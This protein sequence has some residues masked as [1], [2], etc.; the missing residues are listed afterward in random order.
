M[1]DRLLPGHML[2]GRYRIIS[3]VGT[4]GFG[5]VYKAA[6]SPYGDRPVAVKEISL[7]GLKAQE[8]IEATDTFNRE[9]SLLSGLTHPNLP[10]VYDHFTD[11][12]HWYLVME[13][14]EGETLE[15][16][17][18]RH[19]EGHPGAIP[20]FSLEE[21]L[22]M[23]LQ[24]CTVLDYLHKRQPPIIFRDLKPA[25]IMRTP[26]GQLYLIDF[27]IARRFTPGQARDT[28][29]FGSPGYAAP[30]QYG[31]AQTTP[32]ADIYSLGA[33]LHH[34][35]TGNDPSETPFRFVPLQFYNQPTPAALEALIRQMLDV[36]ENKRPASITLVKR[37]L[38]RITAE[39]SRVLYARQLPV[40]GQIVSSYQSVF[41]PGAAARQSMFPP[42][43]ARRSFVPI[44]LIGLALFVIVFGF[45]SS[46]FS[47]LSISPRPELPPLNPAPSGLQRDRMPLVGASDLAT[48]DPA[49]AVDNNS[50]KAIDM[51]FTGLV[52]LDDSL[53]IRPQLA[54]SWDESADGLTWTFHLRPNLRFSDGTSLTANDVTYS[55][56]RALQPATKSS[57]SL[58]YL[59]LIK[60]AG[61]LSAGKIRTI[62]GDSVFAPDVQ[63]V[64]LMTSRRAAYFL[65]TLAY[66]CSY[67]VEQR[68]IDTY[69]NQKF[70]DHLSAGGGDGPF[71]VVQYTHGRSID[72]APNPNYYGPQPRL[73]K[74]SFFFYKDTEASYQAFQAG[75]L[76]MTEVPPTSLQAARTMQ[77]FHQVPELL[78]YY[79]TMNYLVKPFD[80]MHIRQA[81]ALAINKDLIAS[82]IWHDSRRATNHIVPEGMPGYDPRLTGP[83]GI[84]S[85]AGDPAR[86]KDLLHEGLKEEG[87]SSVAELPPIKFTYTD[88]SSTFRHE[89][90]ALQQMWQSVLGIAVETNALPVSILLDSSTRF[91][92][93]QFCAFAW[94]A[95]YPDPEDWM[96][97]QF[98]A[99]SLYNTMNYGQNTSAGAA[100]QQAVQQL[101]VAADANLDENARLQLYNQAEQQLV[102]DVA[103]IPMFQAM[104]SFLLKPYVVGEVFNAAGFI[105]PDDWANIFI[106][107]H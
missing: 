37:E 57:T 14:I 99:S 93:S 107:A 31:K 52:S 64:V 17:L 67:V 62:I 16:I 39:Q 11:P 90:S 61:K 76:D 98:G 95:D 81:F 34:L 26:T 60:D 29:P 70:T 92:C 9:V 75:Q 103:W 36:N 86:A 73:G 30:E 72:F 13:F 21:V 87:W 1:Q 19:E 8:A 83:D 49:L 101:L 38:Q 97:L 46:F 63:T 45:G 18:H 32:R 15:E 25:N 28:M 10:R 84:K 105:P 51:V 91:H 100:E 5:A 88:S 85:T 66:P 89:A 3:Q 77:A 35:L 43:P 42:S 23:A 82:L 65:D 47:K 79:Y 78:T 41:T 2:N 40:S 59:G 4:G 12:E 53:N 104:T 80:N 44:L 33:T 106:A 54:S 24:L 50:V 96:T 56:D 68:L 55:I 74:V 27:G 20:A 69:G 22:E 58:A 102:N 6:D 94:Q 71:E 48:F 7:Y